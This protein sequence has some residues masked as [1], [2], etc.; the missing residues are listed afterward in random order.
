MSVES[1]QKNKGGRPKRK[2]SVEGG[3]LTRARIDAGYSLSDV[4]KIIKCNK[5]TISRWERN[6][7]TPPPEAIL[8]ML[9]LYKTGHVVIKVGGEEN[10]K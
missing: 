5:S 2:I 10:G 6:K 7:K 1:I 9:A 4:A 8:Q 3:A